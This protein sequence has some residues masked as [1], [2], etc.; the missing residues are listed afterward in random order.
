[1]LSIKL[2]L[3]TDAT[4]IDNANMFVIIKKELTYIQPIITEK[5]NRNATKT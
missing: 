1:M 4:V 3:L 2:D 5:D